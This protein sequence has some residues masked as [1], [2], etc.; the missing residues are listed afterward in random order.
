MT[1]R[2]VYL[3]GPSNPDSYDLFVHEF[4]YQGKPYSSLFFAALCGIPHGLAQATPVEQTHAEYVQQARI[5]SVMALGV[6]IAFGTY[7]FAHHDKVRA[8]L[9]NIPKTAEIYIEGTTGPNHRLV[10]IEDMRDSAHKQM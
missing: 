1:T 6:M 9:R 5:N 10:P 8:A 7:A 2:T 3:I 4:Q